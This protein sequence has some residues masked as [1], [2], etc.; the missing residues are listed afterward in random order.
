MAE[1]RR[2]AR[3]AAIDDT[4]AG[5]DRIL[6]RVARLLAEAERNQWRINELVARF[7][8]AAGVVPLPTAATRLH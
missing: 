4:L 1:A 2:R 7:E 3:G 6:T 5:I 8:A